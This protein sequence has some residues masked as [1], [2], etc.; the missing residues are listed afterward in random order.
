MHFLKD[1]YGVWL[2]SF[3]TIL[4]LSIQRQIW[5]RKLK[6]AKITETVEKRKLFP[7]ETCAVSGRLLWEI[8][9]PIKKYWNAF[10]LEGKGFS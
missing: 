10:L 8:Y 7:S 5:Q 6:D 3:H 2:I 1:G 4:Y 9:V